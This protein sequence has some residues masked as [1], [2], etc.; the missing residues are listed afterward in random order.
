MSMIEVG[1]YNFKEFLKTGRLYVDKTL[2][3]KEF[4]EN[5]S[6]IN[7]ITRPRRFGKTL[8]MSML[9]YFFDYKNKEDN[10]KLFDGLNISKEKELCEK[11]Q[12]QYPVIYISLIDCIGD[13]WSDCFHLIKKMISEMYKDHL[14]LADILKDEELEMYT[15][16]SRNKAEDVDYRD[17]LASL[18]KYIKKALGKDVIVLIDEYDAPIQHAYSKDKE[19]FDKMISLK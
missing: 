11:H 6:K 14:Y 2:F 15:L 19:Y 10:K 3:I 18:I 4:I 5:S 7:L 12:N 1:T 9:E 17:A 13:I 16:I 8:N